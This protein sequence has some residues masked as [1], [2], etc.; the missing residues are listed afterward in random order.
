MSTNHNLTVII[1]LT[2]LSKYGAIKP[3]FSPGGYSLIITAK[4]SMIYGMSEYH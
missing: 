4:T 1:K 3:R 2:A